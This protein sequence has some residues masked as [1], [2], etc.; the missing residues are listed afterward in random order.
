M[1]L[2]LIKELKLYLQYTLL[3]LIQRYH[4]SLDST[5]LAFTIQRLE[6]NQSIE[7]IRF[8]DVFCVLTVHYSNK[9]I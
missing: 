6:S 7:N 5:R 1:Y 3:L 4:T 8:L 2:H 9:Q